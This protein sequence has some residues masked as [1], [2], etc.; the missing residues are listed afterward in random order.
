MI[1]PIVPYGDPI[2]KKKSAPIDASFS[3]LKELI[4]DMYDTMYGAHGVGLAAPQIGQSIRLFIVDG[5]PFAEES[6][7]DEPGEIDLDAKSLVDF[8]KVFINP[9]IINESG[10]K[11]GFTEGCLSIPNIREEVM[12]QP[13]I[14]L[15]YMDENLNEFE[16]T[17]TGY[18]ARIIQHEYDHLEGVL[19]TD[20]ISVLRRRM[21]KGKLNDISK[22]KTDASYRMRFPIK[23]K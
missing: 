17:F 10:E 14:V 12:R 3:G 21:L 5:A 8:K 13:D 15:R 7:D 23:L 2:L 19:F 6:E 1:L 11:W 16:E 20:R 18:R 9:Q 22:G 4:S